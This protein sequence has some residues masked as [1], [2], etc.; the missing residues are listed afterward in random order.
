MVIVAHD[1]EVDDEARLVVQAGFAAVAQKFV[2]TI[3]HRGI[4]FEGRGMNRA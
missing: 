3:G 1:L 4:P 2:D